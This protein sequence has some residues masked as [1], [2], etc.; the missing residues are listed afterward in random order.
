MSVLRRVALGALWALAGVGALCALIWGA[1]AAGLIKPLIVVSGS[2]EPEIMTGDLLIATRVPVGELEVGDVA[3]LPS[4]LTG[5]LVTHRIESI[6]A[7]PAGGATISMKGDANAFGDALDYRVAG[8]VWVPGVQLPGVGTAVMRMTTP[9]VAVPLLIGLACLFWLVWILPG[10][11]RHSA[12]RRV[13]IAD[14][15]A[16]TT[17]GVRTVD[18]NTAHRPTTRR[19]IRDRAR[20][21]AAG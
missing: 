4:E 15:S 18:P 7:E 3:S 6:T 2:M 11:A 21:V 5:G 20:S 16:I 14:S 9:A 19:A 8:E 13:P 10:P 12:V 17:A 1:T